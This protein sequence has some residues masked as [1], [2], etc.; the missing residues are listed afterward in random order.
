MLRGRAWHRRPAYL[1]NLSPKLTKRMTL[2]TRF[3]AESD[4]AV[5][6]AAI[7]SESLVRHALDQRYN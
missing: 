2:S 3:T 6:D 4:W 1:Y 5:D 7:D